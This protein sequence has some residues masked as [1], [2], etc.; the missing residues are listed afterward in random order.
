MSEPNP[1]TLVI[2]IGNEYRGDDAA[3]LR[4]ARHLKEMTLPG[5]SVREA[6]GEGTALMEM[7]TGFG[8][9]ILIDAV[10]SGA[11]PGTVHRLDASSDSIPTGF[12]HYSTHAFSVAEAIELARALGQLPRQLFVYGIEGERFAAGVGLSPAVEAAVP[13]VVRLLRE[14]IEAGI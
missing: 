7:W 9:V 3:G 12:F 5:V 10:Q 4:V 6:S 14:T 8:S 11:E 2:G 13:E 1:P